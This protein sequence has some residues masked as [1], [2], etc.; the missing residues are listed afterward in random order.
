MSRSRRVSPKVNTLLSILPGVVR[1]GA[2]IMSYDAR[3]QSQIGFV[4]AKKTY[5]AELGSF[6]QNPPAPVIQLQN[7]PLLLSSVIIGLKAHSTH[8]GAW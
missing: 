4:L 8:V 7:F 1:Q 5:P 2:L 6:W 3:G